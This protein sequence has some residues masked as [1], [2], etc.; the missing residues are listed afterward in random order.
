MGCT[1]P[2][3]ALTMVKKRAYN[4]LSKTALSLRRLGTLHPHKI[5]S[6]DHNNLRELESTLLIK[7]HTK[8]ININ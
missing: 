3:G 5:I 1:G 6:L 7:N 2:T 4:R 8:I